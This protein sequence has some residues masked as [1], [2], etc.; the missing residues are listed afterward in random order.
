M[1]WKVVNKVRKVRHKLECRMKD[2]HGDVKS[3]EEEVRQIIIIKILFHNKMLHSFTNT[4]VS[5]SN[6]IQIIKQSQMK[7]N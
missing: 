2:D 1:F 5:L 3:S 6:L 7:A 4:K